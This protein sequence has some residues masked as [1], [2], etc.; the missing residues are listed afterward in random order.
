MANSRKTNND[1]IS[2]E[3][4]SRWLKNELTP[5]ERV[6]LGQFVQR[7][8]ANR[9]YVD[10]IVGVWKMMDKLPGVQSH[11]V[12]DQWEL[13]RQKI[14]Q[15]GNEQQIVG[16]SNIYQLPV[17]QY[18]YVQENEDPKKTRKVF[19][20]LR[21]FAV[22]ATII[23]MFGSVLWISSRRPTVRRATVISNET[24][25]VTTKNRERV[26]VR[27]SDGSE[28]YLNANSRLEVPQQF[29]DS[30]RTVQ[31]EGQAFFAVARQPFR[32]FIVRSGSTVTQVLGTEF[33]VRKRGNKVRVV[34]KSGK[35]RLSREGSAHGV[36]L[37][38]GEMSIA[39]ADGAISLPTKVDIRKYV[40]WREGKLMFERTPLIEVMG[41]LEQQFG[42]SFVLKDR[43][44][45]RRRFTGTF[46]T[47]SLKEI[48]ST[49]ALALDVQIKQQKDSILVTKN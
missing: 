11:S 36:E 47:D 2:P 7:S 14:T 37:Q 6:E 49:L 9:Q 13:L 46:T 1:S 44:L 20:A 8:Q 23:V 25:V 15:Q 5:D 18:R 32:P 39:N 16:K 41:E 30:V 10:E 28:V 40:G 24:F 38:K 12:S 42:F 48:L 43:E 21:V 35:V 22:A 33:D 4:I 34:V 3:L 26:T 17:S 45:G 29:L 27:L 19:S 31:L